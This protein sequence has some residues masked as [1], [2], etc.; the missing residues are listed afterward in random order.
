MLGFISEAIN[1]KIDVFFNPFKPL[2]ARIFTAFAGQSDTH[3]W[4]QAL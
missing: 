1:Y 2:S 4:G 3:S